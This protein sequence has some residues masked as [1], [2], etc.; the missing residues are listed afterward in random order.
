MKNEGRKHSTFDSCENLASTEPIS[1][2]IFLVL[3]GQ[4]SAVRVSLSLLRFRSFYD[5]WPS[6]TRPREL[7]GHMATSNMLTHT[8]SEYSLLRSL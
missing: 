7:N 2:S 8:L 4:R 6:I 5:P 3:A 1:F